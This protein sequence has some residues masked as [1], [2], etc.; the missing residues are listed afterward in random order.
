MHGC[1][2]LHGL[3]ENSLVERQGDVA[4]SKGRSYIEGSVFSVNRL[5]GF[6]PSIETDSGKR[7]LTDDR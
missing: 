6:R 5:L 4:S 2:W 3:L 7:K 1:H